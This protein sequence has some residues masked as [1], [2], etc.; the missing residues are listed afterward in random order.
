[1]IAESLEDV[2]LIQVWSVILI[3]ILFTSGSRHTRQ[4]ALVLG[5]SLYDAS[6]SRM[7]CMLRTCFPDAH[8]VELVEHQ[9]ASNGSE[10]HVN[11]KSLM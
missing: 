10:N 2:P 7:P 1:M 6:L 3:H 8:A 9:M 11:L 5:K 4:Q